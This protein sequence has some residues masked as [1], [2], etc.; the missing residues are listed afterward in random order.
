MTRAHVYCL[1]SLVTEIRDRTRWTENVQPQ[2]KTTDK[3]DARL[4]HSDMCGA[5]TVAV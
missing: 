4:Q 3:N 1:H 5:G 2:A